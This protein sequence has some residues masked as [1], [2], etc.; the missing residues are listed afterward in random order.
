M[1]QKRTLQRHLTK[2]LTALALLVSTP[3]LAGLPVAYDADLKA[4]KKNVHLGDPL[5]FSLY[6]TPDC[7]GEPVFA[8]ILGA[9]TPEVTVEEVKPVVSVRSARPAADSPQPARLADVQKLES[10]RP[11]SV[12]DSDQHGVIRCRQSRAEQEMP[13]AV[14][15]FSRFEGRG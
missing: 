2:I 13:V 5:G 3:V 14:T 11:A 6:T 10:V 15:H 8:E 7:A 4:L 12:R 9:G 1:R